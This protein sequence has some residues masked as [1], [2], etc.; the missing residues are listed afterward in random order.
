MTPRALLSGRYPVL[1][2]L[3]AALLLL[4]WGLLL[5]PGLAA[6]GWLAGLLFWLGISLGAF[7]LLAVHALTGGAWGEALDGAL[8]PAAAALPAFLPLALPLAFAMPALYPWV[9]DPSRVP[10]ADVAALYLNPPGALL[11]GG[12]SLLL[13]SV[14]APL[15]A[16]LRGAA[17]TALGAV[18]LLL[19][20]VLLTVLSVDWLLSIDPRYHSTAFALGLLVMQVLAALAWAALLKPDRTA[21]LP[22][23]LAGMLVAAALG[24]LYLTYVQYLTAWYGDLP[25]KASWFLLRRTA[26]WPWVLA[27]ALL[28]SGLLPLCG[29]MLRSWRCSPTALARIGLGVLAGLWLHLLW[30]AGPG[31]GAWS[32]LSGALG[33]VAVG[34]A[35]T[36]LARGVL[37]PRLRRRPR[38]P[39]GG[40]PRGPPKGPPGSPAREGLRHG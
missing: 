30:L 8:V 33:L 6:V 32:L 37:A 25:D 40:P 39:L 13:W 35:W 18:A 29:A 4:G 10:H 14:L 20:V 24:T 3:L 2:G 27:A 1:A 38:P 11:R 23:D 31:F 19:H 9:A 26:P 17:R 12:V 36:G 5:S 7:V 21:G 15:L 16:L 34:G 22:G 28:L